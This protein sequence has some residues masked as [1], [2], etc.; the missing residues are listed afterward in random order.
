MINTILRRELMAMSAMSGMLAHGADVQAFDRLHAAG[1]QPGPVGLTDAVCISV[2]HQAV[3][4]ADAMIEE[5]G[6]AD[7]MSSDGFL[8]ALCEGDV[9]PHAEIGHRVHL[10]VS[11]DYAAAMEG[12]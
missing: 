12:L 9:L 11:G 1:F 5:L 2:A 3:K 6:D 4:M 7:G 8:K 10:W